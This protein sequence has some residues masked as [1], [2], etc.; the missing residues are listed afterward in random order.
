MLFLPLFDHHHSQPHTCS[1]C[2]NDGKTDEPPPLKASKVF[3][4]VDATDESNGCPVLMQ[5]NNHHQNQ[6]FLPNSSTLTPTTANGKTKEK[7]EEKPTNKAEEKEKEEAEWY[8]Q[9]MIDGNIRKP[10]VVMVGI[11]KKKHQETIYMCQ[12]AK[13]PDHPCMHVLCAECYEMVREARIK[14]TTASSSSTGSNQAG[15]NS[16]SP[17]QSSRAIRKINKVTSRSSAR[18]SLQY[19]SST[20]SRPKKNECAHHQVES[21]VPEDDAKNFAKSYVDKNRS[22]N[23]HWPPQECYACKSPFTDGRWVPEV[24]GL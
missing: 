20:I 11:N 7:E 6:Q 17:S 19:S 21:F 10:T 4:V 1:Q 3:D 12:N 5:N 2:K 8:Q 15:S 14:T 13:L 9:L 22:Q 24:V 18:R 16:G 23:R